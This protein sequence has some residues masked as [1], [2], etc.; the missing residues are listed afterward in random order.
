MKNFWILSAMAGGMFALPCFLILIFIVPEIAL[1]L[2]LAAGILF[3][4]M[5]FACLLLHE[6]SM[7]KKFSK[8]EATIQSPILYKTTADVRFGKKVKVG[9]LYFCEDGITFASLEEKPHI[10]HHLLFEN[11]AMWEFVF[12]HVNIHMKDGKIH[13]YQIPDVPE[14]QE[15]LEEKGWGK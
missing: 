14:A 3:M 1:Q 2:S 7:N 12:I 5:L 15:I 4:L 8:F 11:I 13:Q 10:I 9:N 6:H